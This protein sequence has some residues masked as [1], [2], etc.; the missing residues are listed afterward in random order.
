VL[1][2]D[3]IVRVLRRFKGS[4]GGRARPLRAPKEIRA[5]HEAAQAFA[6]EVV[7]M[8]PTSH[9]YTAGQAAALAW[10]T[11]DGP[12]PLMYDPAL[13][14]DPAPSAPTAAAVRD[15]A[16]RA[17][18]MLSD[19]AVAADRV[20]AGHATPFPPAYVMGV[21]YVCHWVQRGTE[22]APIPADP[23]AALRASA[24]AEQAERAA[25]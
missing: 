10:L 17:A 24:P 19:R 2:D 21:E 20:P 25:G 13:T 16:A 11:A 22:I 18:A 9:Q 1:G 4:A 3:A 6:T 7:A 15:L 23:P 8:A 5:Q 14:Y 12:S